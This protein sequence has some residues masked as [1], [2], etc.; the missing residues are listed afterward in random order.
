MN[1]R[2]IAG[3]LYGVATIIVLGFSIYKIVI[4]EEIG[5]NEI[6]TIGILVSTYFTMITWGSREEKDGIFPDDELGQ[7]ITE[8][9]A[10]I[11]Y[12]V[13]LIAIFI[14]LVVDKII[15]GD[16]NIVLLLL[17]TL[18]MVTLP[19]IEYIYSKKF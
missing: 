17:M 15:N 12:F 4:G 14:A 1:S 8:K 11:G 16:S 18:A 19:T 2:K 7:R 9:S 3:L 5:F 13:L 10:K 6:T